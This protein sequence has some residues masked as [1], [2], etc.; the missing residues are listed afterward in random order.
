MI[1]T[2]ELQCQLPIGDVPPGAVERG[3]VLS[4]LTLAED[5]VAVGGAAESGGAGD[6]VHGIIVI[7]L[8]QVMHQQNGDAVFV[9]QCF[10]NADVPV[11][12]GILVCVIARG[13]DA[14]ERVD[15]DEPGL[16]MLLQ[17]LLDLFR[18]SIVELLG[19]HGEVQR[20]RRVLCEIEEAA[21]DILMNRLPK[22]DVFVG[23]MS[24][25]DAHGYCSLGIDLTY[26]RAGFDSAA[27]RIMQ[28]NPNMP[29]VHGETF[30]H[31]S[32]VQYFVPCNDPLI[33][34]PRPVI[35]DV[36]MALGKN[37]ADLIED[38][39]TLQLGIGS[40]PDA[41]CK[42]LQ[43]KN[44][45]GIHSEM[46]SDGVMELIEAGVVNNRKKT[47]HR[48]KTVA[49]FAMGTRKLYD[50]INDNPSFMLMDGAYVNDA[51]II[52]Q[53][54]K[55]ISINSCVEI[56][57]YGQAASESVGRLQI[58]G[59]GGQTDFV[60][61]ATR[62]PGGKS[63]I[64]LQSTA[65]GGK[66]SKI[67]PFLG[68]GTPVTLPRTDIDYVVTEYGVAA[69]R[70]KCIRERAQELIHIAHPNFREEL[71]EAWEKF[72]CQKFP[73]EVLN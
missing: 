27:I 57:F 55:M 1:L 15:D 67:V 37:C 68:E 29:R 65:Q 49:A 64:V 14:L 10:Q 59:T 56:D 33:E 60:R 35:S 6:H 32:Q 71:I 41:I 36:E 38:G 8:P 30:V 4:A 47:L 28:V 7:H 5:E 44:D 16:R 21:L 23:Q 17:K 69:L 19:H 24:P 66:R 54:N 20:G 31:V 73:R 9:R 34:I 45:L 43:E 25:P 63:L 13:A 52:A 46:I 61:G 12:A 11:V 3:C 48:G 40:L 26:E 2:V 70:G 62:S 50:F 53:N 18:Q 39:S 58:S 22:I 42:F 72:F 51:A